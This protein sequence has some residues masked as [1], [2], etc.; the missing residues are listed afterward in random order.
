[1][2]HNH[3][4]T[5]TEAEIILHR[6]YVPDAI[7]ETLAEDEP[8]IATGDI[9]AAIK[10]LT[11]YVAAGILP[12]ELSQTER[13]VLDDV[14]DGNTFAVDLRAAV[15]SEQITKNEASYIRRVCRELPGKLAGFYG[16]EWADIPTD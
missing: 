9:N 2:P 4:I 7:A 16:G 1:M 12:P 13:L 8:N 11:A 3:T 5:P 15:G 6:L 10:R 14:L